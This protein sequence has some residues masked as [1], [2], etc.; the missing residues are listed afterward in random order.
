MTNPN[1]PATDRSPPTAASAVAFRPDNGTTIVVV[2]A[3]V[4]S[5]HVTSGCDDV[6]DA[7]RAPAMQHG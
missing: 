6:S 7:S 1:A 4:L 5:L 3:V 2:F